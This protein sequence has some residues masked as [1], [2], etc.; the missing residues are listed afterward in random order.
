MSDI[1]KQ[2]AFER[3]LLE[4]GMGRM[5]KLLTAGTSTPLVKVLVRGPTCPA[6]PEHQA[7]GIAMD[8]EW[9]TQIWRAPQTSC[10]P[11]R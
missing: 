10:G 4:V 1:N 3:K 6:L 2:S 7:C 9:D 5:L 11:E 8:H